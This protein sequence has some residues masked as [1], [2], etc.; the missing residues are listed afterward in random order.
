[1]C[2]RQEEKKLRGKK[3]YT[4]LDTKKD[5]VR[6]TS[7]ALRELNDQFQALKQA[8]ESVQQKLAEEVIKVAG[9]KKTFPAGISNVDNT[10]RIFR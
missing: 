10:V 8:Y 9:I 3:D 2:V 1:M 5:G 4:T 6:F 7:S